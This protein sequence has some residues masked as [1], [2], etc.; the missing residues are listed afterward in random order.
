[1]DLGST[2]QHV[3]TVANAA[4]A[5]LSGV[6]S[7]AGAVRPAL[8]LPKGESV[9]PGVS[10]YARAYTIRALPLSAVALVVLAQHAWS[11]LVPLLVVL[12]LAQVGDS[13]LG[14]RR[15]NLGMAVGAGVGA[16]IHLIS[17]GWIAAH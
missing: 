1:M 11:E 8:G 16:A 4:A 3:I 13:A 5:I 6:S 12:G 15:R 14:V 9:T 7:A 2:A 17:A 10:F